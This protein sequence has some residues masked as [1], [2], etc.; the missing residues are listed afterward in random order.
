[1]GESGEHQD[2]YRG[3]ETHGNSHWNTLLTVDWDRLMASWIDEL[4]YKKKAGL[5]T[6]VATDAG[7][8]VSLSF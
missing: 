8:E 5:R 7:W 6:Q 3:K 4:V 1:L 2:Y